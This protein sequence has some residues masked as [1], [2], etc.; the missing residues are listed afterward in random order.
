MIC[1][2]E[3]ARALWVT[4]SFARGCMECACVRAQTLVYAVSFSWL[5][6]HKTSAGIIIYIAIENRYGGTATV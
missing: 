1:F 2:D 3:Q 6:E 4:L 5:L